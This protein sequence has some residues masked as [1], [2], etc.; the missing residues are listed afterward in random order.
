[1][2]ILYHYNN[3]N[4]KKRYILMTNNILQKEKLKITLISP[5]GFCAGV[6]RA[7]DVIEQA[8]NI[9]HP[10]NKK[11]Y[12]RNE[13][14][15]NKRVVEYFIKKGITF[16]KNL[17][18]ITDKNSILIFSAHGTPLAVEQ[19]AKNQNLHVIDATCPL[20]KKVH[21]EGINQSNQGKDIILVGH[22]GHPELEG[23]KGRIPSNSIVY[24]VTNQEDANSLV[25]RDKNNLAYITQT[26]LS[27][28]DTKEIIDILKER[29]P[30]L[31]GQNTKNICYATQNRQQA[32]KKIIP[33]INMLIIVGSQNSSNSNRLKEIGTNHN[34]PSYLIDDVKNIP[35]EDIL[36]IKHLGIS[37]GASAP[38]D[39]IEEIIFT[40]KENSDSILEIFE[41]TKEDVVFHL[42]KE[43]RPK[44]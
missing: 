9:Y 19:D 14:V 15:H 25:V 44:K 36:K 31:T 20:V 24:I 39:L 40:I 41:D 17:S 38:K 16:I 5:H 13:I 3:N 28:D 30:I 42:P 34:I 32:V 22:S 12:V 43:I 33:K 8:I 2:L 4:T 7:I 37:A 23:T 18:E 1:M 6:S 26:T 35:F 21:L 29:F 27:L 11:I 10:Q